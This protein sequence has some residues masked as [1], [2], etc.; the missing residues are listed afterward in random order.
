MTVCL[1]LKTLNYP[2]IC[3]FVCDKAGTEDERERSF[4]GE[5]NRSKSHSVLPEL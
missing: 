2:F 5:L 4:L 3:V 1:G